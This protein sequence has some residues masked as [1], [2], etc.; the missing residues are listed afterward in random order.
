M[1]QLSK[2]P[3]TLIVSTVEGTTTFTYIYVVRTYSTEFV[4][5]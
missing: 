5:G 1:M 3:L 2:Y 4:F